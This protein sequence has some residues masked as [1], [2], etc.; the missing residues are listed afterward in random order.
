[1]LLRCCGASGGFGRRR[2]RAARARVVRNWENAA[3]KS[4]ASQVLRGF[5]VAR[6]VIGR[7]LRWECPA[8]R[9]GRWGGALG[10]N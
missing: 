10:G 5:R 7:Q 2:G 4:T 9:R 8:K 3:E 1:M 6:L